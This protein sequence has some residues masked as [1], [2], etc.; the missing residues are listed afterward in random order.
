[1]VEIFVGNHIATF[2]MVRKEFHF[3]SDF[4]FLFEDWILVELSKEGLLVE[5]EQYLL[6]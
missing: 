5:K 1:M 4:E 2:V 3:I 6:K